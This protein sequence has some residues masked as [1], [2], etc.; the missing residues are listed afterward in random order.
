[1]R[2]RLLGWLAVVAVLATAAAL[3][4]RPDAEPPPPP[5]RTLATSVDW[6]RFERARIAGRHARALQHAE[7]ATKRTPSGTAGWELFASYL[8]FELAGEHGPWASSP[9]RAGG[10]DAAA[11][12][13]AGWL[14][15]AAE[16]TRRGE[17]SAR[18]PAEL[19]L[20]R[21][22]LFATRAADT[23]PLPWE[24]GRRGLW[25]EAA[26]AFERAAELGRPEFAELAARARERGR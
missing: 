9:E 7:R 10:P 8:G 12:T 25:T 15:A 4:T 6:I 16:V 14:S 13:R 22:V 18:H 20:L 11:R 17:A 5:W 21:G 24:G 19:A 23:E 2:G 3:H 26:A 1:V